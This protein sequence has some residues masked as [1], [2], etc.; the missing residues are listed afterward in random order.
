MSEQVALDASPFH[1]LLR[2][3]AQW[4]LLGLLFE[5]PR[6]DWCAELKSLAA[7]VGDEPLAAC[8]DKAEQEA[9]SGLYHSTFGP[10]GPACP[11]EASHRATLVPGALLAEL[12]AYY[13]GFGY[14]P[15]CLEA[16]DHVAVEAGFMAFLRLK[17][18]YAFANGLSDQAEMAAA[19]A[20]RFL[21]DHLAVIAEPLARSLQ[22]SGIAYLAGAAD[23][24]RSRT[25]K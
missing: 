3:S 22:Q 25:G 20:H 17:Q 7:E 18:A 11:R 6:E 12:E 10:G 19:A 24:L 23:A 21:T 2:E 1:D 15:A 4:R 9:G 16:P 14:Q 8:A 13:Q 5:P